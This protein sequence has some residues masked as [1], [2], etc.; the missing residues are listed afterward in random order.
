MSVYH[1]SEGFVHI[2]MTPVADGYIGVLNRSADRLKPI[3]IFISK[4]LFD[5][6]QRDIRIGL[7]RTNEKVG[8]RG[9]Y[10]DTKDVLKIDAMYNLPNQPITQ[11]L[12]T[13]G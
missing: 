6:I 13:K 10:A 7:L 12:A 3:N 9:H 2:K 4:N 1:E 8:V 5:A 11:H